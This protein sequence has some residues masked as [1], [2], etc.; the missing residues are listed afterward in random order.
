MKRM[1]IISTLRNQDGVSTLTHRLWGFNFGG[2]NLPFFSH[3]QNA[4]HQ[5]PL[6]YL[7]TDALE[8]SQGTL[9]LDNELHH[10][11]E[12]LEGLALP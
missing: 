7:G 3:H 5:D 4:L 9:I 8:Q 12:T 6:Q 1:N 10:L 11:A 2:Y